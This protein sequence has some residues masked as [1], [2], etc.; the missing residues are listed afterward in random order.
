MHSHN[1]RR[2]ELTAFACYLAGAVVFTYPL[3]RD[4]RRAVTDHFDPLLDAWALSWVAHQL[5]RDPA[6]L[7]D[8]NRFYPELGTLAF[9]DPMIGLAI[10]VAPIQWAFQEAVLTLNVAM[11]FA[12]A[13]SGY[14]AYRLVSWLTGSNAACAVAGSVFVFNAYRLNHLSHVQ[15]QNAGFIPLLFLCIS[16]YLEEGRARFAVGVGVFLWFVSASCAY[17]GIFT[18]MFLA[19]AIP[20]ETWRT[21]ALKHP[22]RL[23]GLTLALALSATAYLPLAAPF[24]RLQREFEF[25][26]PVDRLHRMS[27][28]PGDYLRSGSHLHQ[29][30][31]LRPPSRGRTLFPGLLAVGLGL[32]A[33]IKLNRRTGLYLLIGTLAAWASLGPAWGL[34]RILHVVVPGLGGVRSPPRLMIYVLLAAAVLAGQGAALVLSRL[35]GK[36]VLAMAAVLAVF[37]L[38][39]SF[40][41][42]IPYSSAP[43]TPAVYRWLADVPG[44][45]PIVELPLPDV[46][47]QRNNAVYLYWST[48]HFKPMANGFAAFVPPVYAELVQSMK[49]FP[50]D[51]G[52]EALRRLGFRY[53]I[54]HRDRY[55]RF[56]AEQLEGRMHRQ[57]GLRRV[58]RTQNETVYEVME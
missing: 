52:V 54:F 39:E 2:R 32:L 47:R 1:R 9:H 22:R 50:D 17:Y 14:G 44:S 26:R 40:G 42:P 57:N 7:F 28:R 21:S 51:Q 15:L 46:R 48:S 4:I 49:G 41:G 36:R 8:A 13:L 20:Y 3:L 25:H 30:V 10:L 37:P 34:Y 55:L 18:W 38:M 31:G 24:I 12:L 11:L 33:I 27:A 35:Q 29:A 53:V 43:E 45:T 58:Y 6:H 19:L 5:P 16:R 56:R 23:A